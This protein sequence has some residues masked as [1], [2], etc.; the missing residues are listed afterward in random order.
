MFGTRLYLGFHVDVSIIRTY[1]FHLYRNITFKR[2]TSHFLWRSGT[3]A[4]ELLVLSNQMNQE[5][6]EHS[7][8]ALNLDLHDFPLQK[9]TRGCFV[10]WKI[11]NG[12]YCFLRD[13]NYNCHSTIITSNTI[14]KRP[15]TT[16][17]KGEQCCVTSSVR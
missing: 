6:Y 1:N 14:N 9:Q 2:T 3:P 4:Y 16:S 12:N 11:C 5:L 7:L 10:E 8:Y 13:N 17:R 15:N